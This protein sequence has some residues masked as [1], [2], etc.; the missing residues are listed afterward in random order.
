LITQILFAK[1]YKFSTFFSKI[2]IQI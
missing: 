2:I 1:E